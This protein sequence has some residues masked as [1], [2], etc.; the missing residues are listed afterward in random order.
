MQWLKQL[1]VQWE[2]YNYLPP[3]NIISFI[4]NVSIIYTTEETFVK[5]N[6]ENVFEKL[7]ELVKKTI[8]GPSTPSVK[9]SY[10]NLLTSFL[11]HKSGLHFII[12]T[13][14]WSQVIE[15]ILKSDTIYIQKGGCKFIANL[16]QRSVVIN[17]W[18]SYNVIQALSSPLQEAVQN[19]IS[20][21]D[22]YQNLRPTLFILNQVFASLLEL[23]GPKNDVKIFRIILE[24][25]A[26]EKQIRLLQSNLQ[27]EE[28]IF[29]FNKILFTLSF[30]D[31]V[32]KLGGRHTDIHLGEAKIASQKMFDVFLDMVNRGPVTNFLKLLF[33]GVIYWDYLKPV[34]PLCKTPESIPVTFEN[35]LLALQLFP[36]AMVNIKFFGT[37]AM[38][39]ED[40][41]GEEDHMKDE[42]ESQMTKYLTADTFRTTFK[43]KNYLQQNFSFDHATLALKYVMQS[44]KFYSRETAKRAFQMIVH[45]LSDIKLLLKKQPHQIV[46]ISGQSNYFCMLLETLTTIINDF[47]I[48]WKD[49]LE[50]ICVLNITASF[51]GYPIWSS[52]VS[53]SLACYFCVS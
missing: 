28:I 46:V 37:A 44:R 16:L 35:Q 9:L 3:P 32:L 24:K 12:S 29:E 8:A 50:S 4:L 41:L 6:S 45:C 18:F 15:F 21:E 34:M 7:I 36:I 33:V 39:M 11:N 52:K 42:F 48:T 25:F 10:I 38:N 17:D 43:W 30:F 23:C 1:I 14:Y 51:L 53:I 47:E 19:N 27:D 31:F 49:C 20:K 26:F 2:N 40:L 13:N 5:L 22:L